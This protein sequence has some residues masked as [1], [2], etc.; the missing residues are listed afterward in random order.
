MAALDLPGD[1]P[2]TG[3]GAGDLVL[4][5]RSRLGDR[6]DVV[7]AACPDRP[8]LRGLFV[9]PDGHVAWATGDEG[10]KVVAEALELWLGMP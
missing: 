3:A 8:A 6:L 7:T 2:L 10:G 5:D 4:A 1:H 9:R